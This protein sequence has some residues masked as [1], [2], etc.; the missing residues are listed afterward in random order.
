MWGAPGEGQVRAFSFFIK[1]RGPPGP[2]NGPF[3]AYQLLKRSPGR[4]A[5]TLANE[6]ARSA[7]YAESRPTPWIIIDEYA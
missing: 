7:V 4:Q 6:P 5:A 3:R 1:G 2:R